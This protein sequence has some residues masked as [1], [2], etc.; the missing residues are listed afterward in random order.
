MTRFV[1]YLRHHALASTALVCSLLAL[2]GA[3][4]ADFSLPAGSVG[5]AQIKNHVIGAQK[6]N[7]NVIAASIRAWVVVQW[8]AG[9]KLVARAS[10]SRVS[11]GTGATV[12]DVMWPNMH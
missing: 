2:A 8:G 11:V 4:Y 6:F 10:S 1:A 3:S 5:A 9:G 12:A 7:Q